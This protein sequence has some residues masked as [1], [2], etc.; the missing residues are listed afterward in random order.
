MTK[1]STS[2]IAENIKLWDVLEIKEHFPF[3][4]NPSIIRNLTKASRSD[5]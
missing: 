2:F 4:S 5:V 3:D 1:E